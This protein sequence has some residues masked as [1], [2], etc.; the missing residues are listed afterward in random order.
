MELLLSILVFF[1]GGFVFAYAF[2]FPR[3]EGTNYPGP[4]FFPKVVGFSL[5]VLSLILIIKN[6]REKAWPHVPHLREK[7][8]EFVN[9]FSVIASV[10]FYIYLSDYLGF[11]LTVSIIMVGLMLLLK[12]PLKKSLYL[13]IGATVITYL[14]FNR[15]LAVPLPGGFFMW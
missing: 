6:V 11:L 10:L 1:S 14:L 5:M 2:T 9:I 7:K 13:G 12:V 15:L 8:R 4:G 3:M